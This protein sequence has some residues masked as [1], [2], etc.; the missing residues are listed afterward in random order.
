MSAMLPPSIEPE[1]IA[2]CPTFASG[3]LR[4][5]VETAAHPGAFADE[6][7]AAVAD[8]AAT[9]LE[10][11]AQHPIISATRELYRRCGKDP[12]RYR[13]AAE[14]LRRRAVR[15]AGP[16][17]VHPLVDIVNWLSL[18]TGFS[19]SGV[20]AAALRGQ[21][22]WGIG[23]AGEPYEAIGRGPLNI[24]GLPVL[25]DDLGP[26]ASPTSDSVR[27]R[28]REDTRDVLI[29]LCAPAGREGLAGALQMARV[30]LVTVL[31]ARQIELHI[32]EAATGGSA[33]TER[34]LENHSRSATEKLQ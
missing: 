30:A 13:P 21:L 2:R 12:S 17:P 3:S 32:V 24:A 31:A 11:I 25:R 4:C 19:I 34:N 22:R 6:L 5:V 7:A 27:A 29:V 33:T 20:D 10:A 8:A 1:L 9:P 16:H 18:R 15:G 26:F 23:R 14:Q 28:I